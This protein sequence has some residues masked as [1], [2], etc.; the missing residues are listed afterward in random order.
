MVVISVLSTLVHAVI[1]LLK[2]HTRIAL[3]KVME[4]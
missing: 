2:N 4:T 3:G 1:V